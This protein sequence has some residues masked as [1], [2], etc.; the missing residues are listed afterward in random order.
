MEDGTMRC[1]DTGDY[2][3]LGQAVDDSLVFLY[4]VVLGMIMGVFL[5]F[6][7]L[8]LKSTGG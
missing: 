8:K 1:R 3:N 7:I 2:Q 6:C 4:S 5:L